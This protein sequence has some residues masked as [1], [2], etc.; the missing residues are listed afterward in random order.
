MVRDRTLENRTP[1]RSQCFWCNV[2][3]MTQT[4]LLPICMQMELSV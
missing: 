1:G 2:A 4:I 3:L